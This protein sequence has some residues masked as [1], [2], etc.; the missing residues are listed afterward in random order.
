MDCLLC[1]TTVGSSG[2]WHPRAC[3]SALVTVITL[4]AYW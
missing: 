2:C 1:M 4:S 3:H